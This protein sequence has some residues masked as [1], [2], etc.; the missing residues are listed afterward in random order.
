MNKIILTR[1]TI[2]TTFIIASALSSCKHFI[3]RS[4]GFQGPGENDISAPIKFLSRDLVISTEEKIKQ[5]VTTASLSVN[6]S[7]D[8]YKT[9][10]LAAVPVFKNR[11]LTNLALTV[12]Y[13][14]VNRTSWSNV[15]K[16]QTW[17]ICKPQF[18]RVRPEGIDHEKDIIET[19]F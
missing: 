9:T 18:I 1:T 8:F 4:G 3:L 12:S 19:L 2:I 6:E 13:S 5:M 16:A 11:E 14:T 17:I 10:E 15:S 7:H